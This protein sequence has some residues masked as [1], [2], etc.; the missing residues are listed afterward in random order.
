MYKIWF[1]IQ[2]DFSD[3]SV[4]SISTSSSP[5]QGGEPLEAGDV[6]H[7]EKVELHQ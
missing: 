4:D 3:P 1:S 5:L 6:E 7:Q 2:Q